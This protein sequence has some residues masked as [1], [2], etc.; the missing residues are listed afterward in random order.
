MKR[1]KIDN[2]NTRHQKH[3]CFSHTFL[4]GIYLKLWMEFVVNVFL[5]SS[6]EDILCYVYIHEHL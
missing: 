3:Q 6:T 2:A 5:V 1:K 4:N